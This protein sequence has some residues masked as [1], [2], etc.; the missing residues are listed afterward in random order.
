[1]VCSHSGLGQEASPAFLGGSRC[2]GSGMG[3]RALADMSSLCRQGQARLVF[4][5]LMTEIQNRPE[6]EASPLTSSSVPNGAV[7]VLDRPCLK[8]AY[9][10]L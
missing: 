3:S 6:G 7:S 10:H 8:H 2:S 4:L 1:M 9:Y 5:L